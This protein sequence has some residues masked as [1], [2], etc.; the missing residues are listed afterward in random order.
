MYSTFRIVDKETDNVP[1]P[2]YT[3]SAQMNHAEL[4]VPLDTASPFRKVVIYMTPAHPEDKFILK[5][6]ELWSY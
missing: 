5:N 1:E 3:L 6:I 4:F 2:D